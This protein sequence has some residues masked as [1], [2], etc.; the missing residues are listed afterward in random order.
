MENIV[1]AAPKPYGQTRRYISDVAKYVAKEIK[2]GPG[3]DLISLVESVGGRVTYQDLR[4]LEKSDSGSI[5]VEPDG[6]FEIT[7]PNHTSMQRDRFTIAHEMGHLVLHFMLNKGR[8][9]HEGLAA[10]RYGSGLAEYEA[11]W[12]AAS[13]LMPDDAFG[14][15]YTDSGGDLSVVADR[16]DVSLT[17]ASVR[18][19][20]L[21]LYGGN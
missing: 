15:C 4:D 9:E 18:A 5:R 8:A 1:Y 13:F 3:D 17:A 6:K 12:F 7:L 11:N 21:G 14:L 10:S 2:C 20:S 19:K 16:F